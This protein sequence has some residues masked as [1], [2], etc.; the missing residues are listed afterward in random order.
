MHI[1]E[2]VS[3]KHLRTA[4]GLADGTRV[5][6]EAPDARPVSL[7]RKLGWAAVWACRR[8]YYYTNDSYVALTKQFAAFRKLGVQRM[9]V[10]Q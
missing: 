3:D 5:T 10:R 9:T 7:L 1:I 2:V 6:I 8:D 4:L